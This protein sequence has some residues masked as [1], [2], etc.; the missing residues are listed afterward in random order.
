MTCPK[1]SERQFPEGNFFITP[2]IRIEQKVRLVIF[3]LPVKIRFS[4]QYC[5]KCGFLAVRQ[6]AVG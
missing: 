3:W 2:E 1:C 4:V 5:P 6:L